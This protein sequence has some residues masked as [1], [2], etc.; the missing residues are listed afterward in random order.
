VDAEHRR[1]VEQVEEAGPSRSGFSCSFH[2]FPPSAVCMILP[3]SPTIQ[4][5]CAIDELDAVEDRVGGGEALAA[6]VSSSIGTLLAVQSCRRRW[7][8]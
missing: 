8:W 5:C 4:P 7:S 1:Q 3:N 6:D 2:V